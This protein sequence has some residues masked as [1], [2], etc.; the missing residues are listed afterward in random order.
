M[1]ARTI[2]QEG[3]L[4]VSSKVLGHISE[5]LYRGPAGVIK[6]LI[7]NAYDA[8]AK[9]VW[10]S[11]GRP[12]FDV[13]S[14]KDDGDGMT[15]DKFVQ[16]MSGGIGDSDKRIREEPLINGRKTI[17]RLGIGLLG[18][19][20]ISHEFSIVSHSRDSRTA[21]EATVRM[22][23]F[24]G[25]ILDQEPGPSPAPDDGS[26]EEIQGFQ[27]GG[28]EATK[29]P[30]EPDNTGMTITATDPTEG[31][32]R[33]MSED[34]PEPLPKA[35]SDFARWALEKDNL[36]TGPWYNQM[37]WQIASLAPVQYIPGTAATAGD[38]AMAEIAE[39]LEQFEFD[40][41][42]DGVKLYKPVL[43][44]GT[45]VQVAQSTIG[46]GGGSFHFPLE[47]DSDV[48]GSHLRISGY[49][50]ASGGTVLHPHEM[51]GLLIRLKHIGIGGYDKSFLGYRYA[52][53]PRFGWL[54]GELFVDKGLEDALT[55]GRDGFDAGHPH[56]IALRQWVHGELRSR[57]FPTLHR[58]YAW[59]R[60]FRE[61]EKQSTRSQGFLEA[62]SEF[63]GSQ[64]EISYVDEPSLPPV[65]VDLK[66]GIAQINESAQWPRG[67]RQRETIQNICMIFELVR[68]GEA[69]PDMLEN[70]KGLIE[71]LLSLR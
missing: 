46:E 60:E 24:R 3:S 69:E 67:K 16:L 64:M 2:T 28:Y 53:G 6:E 42:I 10:V 66:N 45:A 30:Y 32:R 25:E 39:A 47:F 17:G 18:I 41:I 50:H 14:V 51:R 68:S 29:I 1:N 63:A 36:A 70:F 27:V 56:Y 8:N 20:Q 35:F 34:K 26:Q 58:G 49:I 22:K 33:Q 48:W 9:T 5:G 55:V 31:F 61:A 23:D 62:I 19:S 52:E 4:M 54:T 7:S 65:R 43:L 57:V 11:T 37:I 12:T 44:Y 13:I 40:V 59:R 71:K 15:L 21:F 38:E